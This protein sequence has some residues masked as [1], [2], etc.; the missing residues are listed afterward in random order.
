MTYPVILSDRAR[1]QLR[2]L[3]P[4]Q[5]R[6]VSVW[7]RNNIDG[8]S[9]PRTHGKALV[10][11]HSGEWVYRIGVYRVLVDIQDSKLIVLALR[12]GHRRHIYR[13]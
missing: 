6:L 13:A 8:S 7:L 11:D 4:I 10:G 3:D 12:V 5:S 1:K 9:D 2:K